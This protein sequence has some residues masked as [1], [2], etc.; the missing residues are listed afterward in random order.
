MFG[1]DLLS[2]GLLGSLSNN[3][4]GTRITQGNQIAPIRFDAAPSVA[5]RGAML[6]WE[7]SPGLEVLQGYRIETKPRESWIPLTPLLRTTSFVDPA[8]TPGVRY[9][10]IGVYPD[11]AEQMV[12][13]A[14][15]PYSAAVVILRSPSGATIR[16]VAFP[17]AHGGPDQVR[18]TVHDVR[19]S[20]VREWPALRASSGPQSLEWDGR[21]TGGSPVSAGVYFVQVTHAAA[22]PST[23]RYVW[24]RR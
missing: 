9:R 18:I 14:I 3:G 12:A 19:G 23:A 2:S 24:L 17:D 10:L 5:T 11:D 4:T 16:Y 15:A 8:A 6:T 21:A 22:A 7:T 20:V 1:N 13:E